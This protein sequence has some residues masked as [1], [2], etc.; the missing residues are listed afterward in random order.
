MKK[1]TVYEKSIDNQATNPHSAQEPFLDKVSD[2]RF[3]IKT[4]FRS[5]YIL[6]DQQN[7]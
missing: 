3:L 4:A 1:S 6:T 7:K 5:L 2:F